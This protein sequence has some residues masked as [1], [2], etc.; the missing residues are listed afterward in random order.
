VSEPAG[1]S[2]GERA[3]TALR[4]A[5]FTGLLV[6][7]PPSISLFLL[8]TVWGW[9]DAKVV[10]MLP[11]ELAHSTPVRIAGFAMG[12]LVPVSLVMLAGAAAQTYF[13]AQFKLFYER[14]LA[15]V[16]IIGRIFQWVR[17]IAEMIF[18]DKREVFTKVALI[19]YP[20]KGLWTLAFVSSPASEE[21]RRKSGD[22]L[23][24]LFVPTTPNPT[25]GFLIMIPA[26]E[27][28]LLDIGP[29][30][31]LKIILSGGIISPDGAVHPSEGA[32]PR[33]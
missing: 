24:S 13:G 27:V 19:E 21:I 30:E 25:S 11:P 12:I 18:T 28:V 8:Y 23:V 3:G 33:R 20:R 26:R 6:L 15:R 5:F 14:M 32:D 29:E 2:F 9:I 4:G 17:Q 7:I 1:N 31:A 16:P 10:A 22:E